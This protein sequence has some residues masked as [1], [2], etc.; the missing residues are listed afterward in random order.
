MGFSICS[1]RWWRI[2]IAL[3]LH[4]NYILQWMELG[5]TSFKGYNEEK[6]NRSHRRFPLSQINVDF[7]HIYWTYSDEHVTGL[8]WRYISKPTD[9][10]QCRKGRQRVNTVRQSLTGMQHYS[11]PIT[12]FYNKPLQVTFNKYTSGK[13]TS[14][15]KGPTDLC[16]H[17]VDQQKES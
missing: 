17:S 6:E 14:V 13:G 9:K 12:V 5:S 1:L 16:W 3:A 7:R 11:L 15:I 8:A 10:T 2:L 4:E